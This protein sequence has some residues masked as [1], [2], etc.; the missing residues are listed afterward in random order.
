MNRTIEQGKQKLMPEIKAEIERD[1]M[2]S[3]TIPLTC[4]NY[5]EFGF[6]WFWSGL[7][8]LCCKNTINHGFPKAKDGLQIN[9]SVSSEAGEKT[10]RGRFDGRYWEIDKLTY[11]AAVEFPR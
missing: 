5:R 11:V 1:E 9:L 7:P 8:V 10:H 4:A 6:W 2:K 3:L